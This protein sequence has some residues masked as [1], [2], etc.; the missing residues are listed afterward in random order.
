MEALS[1]YNYAHVLPVYFETVM[2]SRIADSP[3][4]AE[5]LQIIADTRTICFSMQYGLEFF[6]V[7]RQLI[8]SKDEVASFY[9]SHAKVAQ[10]KLELL[11]DSFREWE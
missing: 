9:Q 6:D 5:M 4:D 11:V 3:D 2:K 8:L 7:M 1:A 10:K